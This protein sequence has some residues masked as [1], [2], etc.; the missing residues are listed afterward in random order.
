[1]ASILTKTTN[2][3]T[4]MVALGSGG[5]VLGTEVSLRLPQ[6]TILNIDLQ[7]PG[8]ENLNFLWGR[9]LG[10]LTLL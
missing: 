9:H 1:M 3:V 10:K 5:S 6:G 8:P 2:T 4:W 7:R